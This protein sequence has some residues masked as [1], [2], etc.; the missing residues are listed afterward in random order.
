[1]ANRDHDNNYYTNPAFCQ[2]SEYYNNYPLTT[3]PSP[4]KNLSPTRNYRNVRQSPVGAL[5]PSRTTDNTYHNLHDNL[6]PKPGPKPIKFNCDNEDYH[7]QNFYEEM[8]VDGNGTVKRKKLVILPSP[9]TINGN[10]DSPV[11]NHNLQW[12]NSDRQNG[13]RYA[14]VPTQSDV[15]NHQRSP[16]TRYEYIHLQQHS[17]TQPSPHKKEYSQESYELSHRRMHRY[18]V[19]PGDEETELCTSID[20][21]ETA[22]KYATVPKQP[23]S[24]YKP[25]TRYE[26][27]DCIDDP[28]PREEVHTIK[29]ITSPI[30]VKKATNLQATQ[31]LHELLITPQKTAQYPPRLT[32]PH[33]PRKPTD[34]FVASKIT[35][36]K[37]KT[38]KVQQKLNFVLSTHQRVPD[39]RHT[40]IVAPI[41][42]SPVQSV[43]SETTFS[44]KSESWMNISG[45]KQPVHTTLTVAAVMMILCGGLT[46]GL[47]FYMVSFMGRL[48]FLDFGI[49]SGFACLVLGVLGCRSRNQYYW[50][51]N[52]NYMSGY[53][54]LTLFSLLTCVGLLVLLFMQP[55][56]GSP[57]AD[58]TSGAVCGIS[59]LS[60][61]LASAGVM[62]SYCCKL[63][64]PDNR[65]E[66]CARGF[67]V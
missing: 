7:E 45:Q 4:I 59:V 26:Y 47:C 15:Q 63:P 39:K 52:R 51:P 8:L 34:P 24:P 6:P 50:L 64:P 10:Y 65:V 5:S 44:N 18:A 53:I 29:R 33:S 60:L 13:N 56:P 61:I 28:P 32:S 14:I 31:K 62:A 41:C 30:A 21:Y 36:R 9:D 1:M 38:P 19:I 35:P 67:T 3:S 25:N 12:V 40:A 27:I 42:S 58:M 43:Y 55:K 2:N 23:K 46:S 22:Y 54:I 17:S 16:K 66:H 57:F 37:H 20:K 49:V 48:Y 11:P